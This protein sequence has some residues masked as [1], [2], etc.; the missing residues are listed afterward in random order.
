ML[1]L[2]IR[3]AEIVDGSGA[4]ARHGDVGVSDGRIALHRQGLPFGRRAPAIWPVTQ[5]PS[6][7]ARARSSHVNIS[8]ETMSVSS[9]TPRAN[10]SVVSNTG[11]RISP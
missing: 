10:S 2:L 9:P 3:D 11:V 5:T 1:D 8:L 6:L 7:A 4:P